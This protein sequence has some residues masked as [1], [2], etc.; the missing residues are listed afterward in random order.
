NEI[1]SMAI[2][3]YGG[4][5]YVLESGASQPMRDVRIC[6]IYE[7]TTAI[8]AHDFIER[9]LVRDSGAALHT[10]LS[11][12]DE[13]LGCLAL[14]QKHELL[15]IEC[16]LRKGVEL[17]REAA[18]WAIVNYPRRPLV[19]LGGGVALIQLCGIVAGGWQMA[20]AALAAL[21]R[22]KAG[23]DQQEFLR[24]KILSVRFYA[25]HVLPQVAGLAV[26]A[27]RGGESV[28]AMDD[29]AF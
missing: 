12:V 8:Q 14:H 20:R 22:L 3:V 29:A 17:L 15:D 24:R 25:A 21:E 1:T 11:S 16:N 13:T 18:D 26:V 7:G 6:A 9:K 23:G 10:W 4:M 19:V 5:G 2:Q 27:M 28:M